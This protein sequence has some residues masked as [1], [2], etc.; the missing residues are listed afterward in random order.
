MY[1][2]DL[3]Q[4]A[5][6]YANLA[7]NQANTATAY[8]QSAGLYANLAYNQANTGIAYAT[9]AGSYANSSFTQANLAIAYAQSAGNYANGAFDKANAGYILAQN[10][11]DAANLKFNIAG[12]EITGDVTIDGHANVHQSLVVGTGAYTIL[13]NLIA[14]FTGTSDYYSQIN[15]QNLS[16]VGSADVVVTADNGTDSINYI[17]M[18]IAGSVYDNTTPNAFPTSNPNDGY[19]Y[20]VGDAGASYGGNLVVGTTGSGSFSDISIVQG[21]SFDET[22]RFV[23]GQGLTIKKTTSATN[24]TSGALIVSGGVGVSGSIYSGNVYDNGTRKIGRAHV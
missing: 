16:G 18:G 3:A 13:P 11:Y 10:A 14:Q 22:A 19:L 9:S 24:Q 6:L 4:S 15:Q 8:A 1:S 17:D 20:L 2:S 7:Y 23:A 21:N 12:G 5:G